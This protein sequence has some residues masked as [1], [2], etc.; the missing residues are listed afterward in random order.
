MRKRGDGRERSWGRKRREERT[1][2]LLS[3]MHSKHFENVK[4]TL[5]ETER[6]DA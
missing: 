5:L 2:P 3:I 6:T 4:R 1:F